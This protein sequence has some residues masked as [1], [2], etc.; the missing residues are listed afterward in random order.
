MPKLVTLCLLKA[1]KATVVRC[2]TV[3]VALLGCNRERERERENI[4]DR[5]Y[6]TNPNK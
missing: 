4:K 1:L 6:V 5:N 3:N 2:Y